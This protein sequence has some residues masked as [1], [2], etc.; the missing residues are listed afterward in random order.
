MDRN[1]SPRRSSKIRSHGTC[2]LI[3]TRLA[4]H[5]STAKTCVKGR[6]GCAD[7][8]AHRSVPIPL[9]IEPY[10]IGDLTGGADRRVLIVS[11]SGGDTDNSIGWLAAL[12]TNTFG[13]GGALPAGRLLMVR[14]IA[15][16]DEDVPGDARCVCRAMP[17]GR[18]PC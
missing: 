18:A 10:L 9:Q 7:A 13:V 5:L 11:C 2:Q 8:A 14:L 16:D 17:G 1:S 4:G 3:H 6:E 15:V 12:G